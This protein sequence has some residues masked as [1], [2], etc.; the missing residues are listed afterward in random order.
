MS[1]KGWAKYN[2]DGSLSK[3]ALNK[4][5]ETAIIVT[6]IL[7]NVKQGYTDKIEKFEKMVE[8]MTYNNLDLYPVCIFTLLDNDN[9]GD[10]F[11]SGS[12]SEDTWFTFL[13]NLEFNDYEG[14]GIT[15]E[16][17]K[18]MKMLDITKLPHEMQEDLI[19]LYCRMFNLEIDFIHY[20]WDT[21]WS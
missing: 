6:E 3:D 8:D 15:E 1:N 13:E 18:E 16:Q 21:R 5:T 20:V 10:V 4:Q 19:G 17:F 9:Y 14:D 11:S 12:T 2:L 7:A